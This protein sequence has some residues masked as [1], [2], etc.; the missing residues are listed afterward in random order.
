M[1]SDLDASDGTIAA[2]T[3]SSPTQ[4]RERAKILVYSCAIDS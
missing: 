4:P 1:P 2:L 3:P